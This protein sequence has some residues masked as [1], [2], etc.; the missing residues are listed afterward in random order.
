MRFCCPRSWLCRGALGWGVEGLPDGRLGGST[1]LVVPIW[2]LSWEVTEY[3]QQISFGNSLG[4][5]VAIYERLMSSFVLI[6]GD[7]FDFGT[8]G[9]K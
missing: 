7:T 2:T 5:L 6:K 1:A 8:P 4:M 9:T 3:S